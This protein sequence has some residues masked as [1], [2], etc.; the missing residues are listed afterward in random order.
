[1][2]GTAFLRG[3]RV[4]LRTVEEEDA[5]ILQRSRNEPAFR[6]GL[7]SIYPKNGIMVEMDLEQRAEEDDDDSL[8]LLVCVDREPVGFV[9]LFDIHR[10]ETATLSYWLLPEYQSEGYATEGVGLLIDHAF[11]NLALHR[12]LAWTI[13]YNEA[14]QAL[15]RRL[16][17]SHEGTYRE[18]IF[19][20]GEYHDTEHYGLLVS[21]W[22]GYD[23]SE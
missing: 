21:E 22:D 8:G 20:K 15:L 13:D 5:E 1:M 23:V 19:R 18:H 17:F 16:G 3:N 14:S 4:T 7:L 10:G 12:I 9:Y 6:D 2:P 11:Q